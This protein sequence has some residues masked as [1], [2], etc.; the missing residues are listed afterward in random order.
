MEQHDNRLQ[1][2]L[3]RTRAAR[4]QHIDS[5]RQRNRESQRTSRAL[6]RESFVRLAFNY[7]PDINYSADH[8]ACVVHP[9]NLYCHYSLLHLNP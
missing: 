5:F 3:S 4:E 2:Y 7:A 1:D 9:E 8:L 6:T